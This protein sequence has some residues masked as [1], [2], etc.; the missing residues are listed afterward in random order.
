LHFFPLEKS[1]QKKKKK[2]KKKRQLKSVSLHTLLLRTPFD[3]RDQ[4]SRR[5]GGGRFF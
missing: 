5:G 2:K 1:E 3:P 4:T